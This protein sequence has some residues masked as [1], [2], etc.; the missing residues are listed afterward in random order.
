MHRTR[1][2]RATNRRLAGV[3]LVAALLAPGPSGAAITA[4]ALELVR[5]QVVRA[6]SGVW[7]RLDGSF[8]LGDLVQQP[9]EMQVVVREEIG[10][11]FVRWDLPRGAFEGTSAALADG[12]AAED[13]EAV[14]AASQPTRNARLLELASGRIELLLPSSFPA[15]PSQVHLYL[16]YRGEP[17]LSNPL[18]FEIPGAQP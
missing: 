15:G 17:L 1:I 8:P 6:A 12:F 14:E 18:Q 13:I 11:R 3:A 4:P 5:V 2:E 16:V 7:I 9:L 10:T